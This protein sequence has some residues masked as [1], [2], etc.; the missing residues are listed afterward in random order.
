MSSAENWKSPGGHQNAIALQAQFR[1][2]FTAIAEYDRIGHLLLHRAAN[3]D[4]VDGVE[5]IV[6]IAT[7]RRAVTLFAGIRV[8]LENS[9]VDPAKAVARAYF[10]LWLQHRCLA[11][12]AAEP[13]SLETV[14]LAHD[15]EPRARKYYVAAE[16]RGLR[17][18]AMV[19]APTA[20]FPPP[21]NADRDALH[22]ELVTEI[23]RL[24]HEYPGEWTYFGDVTD[25]SVAQ[26]VGGRSEPAWYAAEFPG[27]KVSSIAKLAGE[28]AEAWQYEFLY[29]AFSALV[30]SRGL[31]HDVTIEGTTLGVHHPHDPEWFQ[32]I[33]YFVFGW[34]A[35]L[36]MTAAKW[37]AP[38]MILQL[39]QLH[40]KHKTA[41]DSLC[42]TSIPTM[43]G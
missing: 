40:T 3:V 6:G 5:T 12:G 33:A 24:R 41:I 13:V 11:Y 35:M 37:H 28:Y 22:K 19:L 8:L 17:A 16:R 20:D 39:Q 29:D 38:E 7:L 1:D 30:H 31:A 26:H 4:A 10:E 32:M 23:D 43:L 9:S 42:P 34:H 14:T 2:G 36:L 18:R 27:K 25:A 21:T 15:R